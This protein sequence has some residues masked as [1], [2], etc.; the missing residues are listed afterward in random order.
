MDELGLP[1]KRLLRFGN[2]LRARGEVNE[3]AD[4]LRRRVSTAGEIPSLGLGFVEE[5]KARAYRLCN[6]VAT[7]PAVFLALRRTLLSPFADGIISRRFRR[8]AR[9][10]S[11]SSKHA[12]SAKVTFYFAHATLK[13]LTR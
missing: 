2:S 6:E 13:V 3:G 7:F 1:S 9:R 4:S 5:E 11:R 8:S 10:V 12:K